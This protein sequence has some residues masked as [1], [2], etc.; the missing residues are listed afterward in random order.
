MHTRPHITSSCQI[1]IYSVLFLLLLFFNE[2]I[3]GVCWKK[4]GSHLPQKYPTEQLPSLWTKIFGLNA[5]TLQ[6]DT[7]SLS[8]SANWNRC[9]LERNLKCFLY[10]VYFVESLHTD[11]WKNKLRFLGF[12]RSLNANLVLAKSMEPGGTCLY[13]NKLVNVRLSL[14]LWQLENIINCS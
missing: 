8:H 5:T 13:Y 7:V 14:W 6:T 3:H 10:H 4:A 2:C 11:L 12:G 9:S 1:G